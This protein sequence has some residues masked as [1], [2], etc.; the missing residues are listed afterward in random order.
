VREDGR[1]AQ[2]SISRLAPVA[3]AGGNVRELERET[4]EATA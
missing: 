3:T 2:R 4:K 1:R